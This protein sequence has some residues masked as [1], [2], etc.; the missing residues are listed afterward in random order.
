MC[1]CIYI[2]YIYIEYVLLH[3]GVHKQQL[4]N[5]FPKLNFFDIGRK[6]IHKIRNKAFY[7]VQKSYHRNFLSDQK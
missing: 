7:S 4:V 6:K 2:A 3:C 5:I 1:N